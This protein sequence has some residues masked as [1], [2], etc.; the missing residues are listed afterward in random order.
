MERK[1][2]SCSAAG[3]GN[4]SSPWRFSRGSTSLLMIFGMSEERQN[5]FHSRR[6]DEVRTITRR[7]GSNALCCAEGSLSDMRLPGRLGGDQ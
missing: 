3:P 5:G 4:N 7:G 6:V 1:G 2:P